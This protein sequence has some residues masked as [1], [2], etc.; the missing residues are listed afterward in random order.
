MGKRFLGVTVLHILAVVFVLTALFVGIKCPLYE[1]VHLFCPGCGATRML[2]ALLNLQIYQ[3]FRYNPFILA[4]APLV[5]YKGYLYI[6]LYVKG[7]NIPKQ[8]DKQI[9]AY[10]ICLVIFG[11]LRN[12]DLFGFLQ[13]TV[14]S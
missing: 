4:T 14:I 3:A 9:I 1:T 13:P 7:A 8:L 11:V 2:K 10:A 12:F 6:Y 5:V